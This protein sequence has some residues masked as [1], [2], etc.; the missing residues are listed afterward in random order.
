MIETRDANTDDEAW[1]IEKI[2][3]EGQD[4]DSFNPREFRLA[5]D[6]D[7]GQRMAFGRTEFIRNVDDSEFIEINSFYVLDR[8]E[9]KDVCILITDLANQ[10]TTNRRQ[11][12]FAFPHEY[13]EQFKEVG[14]R[15]VNTDQLP[16]V[17]Q[18]KFRDK[19]EEYENVVAMTDDLSSIEYEV[20][21]DDE[22]EKPE[23][24]SEEEVEQIKDELDIDDGAS[25]KYEI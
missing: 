15:E 22:F 6:E 13:Q 23:G 14:F 21:D 1:M 4:L 25:T 10:A 7:T 9:M 11:Q 2:N 8:A 12:I 20:E 17:M 24:T 5:V 16:Q 3:Q 18:E 19:K